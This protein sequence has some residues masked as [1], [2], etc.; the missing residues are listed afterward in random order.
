MSAI[1]KATSITPPV[2]GKNLWVLPASTAFSAIEVPSDWY[3]SFLTLEA[4]G[5]D[6]YVAFS[7][8]PAA[9]V[10]PAATST[11]SGGKI[12]DMGA[13][14]GARIPEGQIRDYDLS[15]LPFGTGEARKYY[16]A[17]AANSPGSF[18]RIT[19]SSGPVTL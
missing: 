15:M 2:Q 5:A 7:D 9:E 1:S 10:D 13:K 19:R 12:T 8:D 16:L 3:R 14:A 17:F 6:I 4:E 11:V 18:L